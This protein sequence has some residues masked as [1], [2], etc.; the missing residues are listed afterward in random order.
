VRIVVTGANGYFGRALIETLLADKCAAEIVVLVRDVSRFIGPNTF[1][2]QVKV[3]D[4]ASLLRGAWSFSNQDMLCHLAAGRDSQQPAEI[5]ATLALTQRIFSAVRKAK[6]AGVVFAS[7]QAVYG[8]S[9]PLWVEEMPAAPVTNYGVAK[10]ASELMLLDFKSGISD[11]RVC[12]LRFPKLVGPSPSFRVNISEL[13]HVF[14]AS[15]IRGNEL[16]FPCGRHQMLDYM[17]VRDA[18]EA[19]WRL[20]RT[21]SPWPEVLNVGSGVPVSVEEVVELTNALAQEKL[22]RLLNC[23]FVEN[24][25]ADCRDFG[26]NITRMKALLGW[27]SQ[28]SLRETMEDLFDLMMPKAKKP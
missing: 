3:E 16:R 21:D 22:G 1:G 23:K 12:S 26:M 17:D 15:V 11:S 27:S 18:A 5:A 28:Y 6:V 2:D 9:R 8:R 14:V 7:S 19:V 10:Y 20:I 24:S 13:P 4:I 25:K